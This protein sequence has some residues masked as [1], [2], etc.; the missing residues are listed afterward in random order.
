MNIYIEV[1]C[2]RNQSKKLLNQIGSVELSSLA[3]EIEHEA[4]ADKYT[5]VNNNPA[6]AKV[7]QLPAP[8]QCKI[9]ALSSIYKERILCDALNIEFDKSF[10]ILNDGA[11]AELNSELSKE[12]VR[13]QT[14]EESV[15]GVITGSEIADGRLK[16][17]AIRI[18]CVFAALVITYFLISIIHSIVHKSNESTIKIG[19][20]DNREPLSQ[21]SAQNSQNEL[22][23]VSQPNVNQ[24]IASGLAT[25]SMDLV[26][27]MGKNP[28]EVDATK[29]LYAFTDPDCPYCK[30]IE[31][32]F[33]ALAKEG[34]SI[35][36]FPVS[37]HDS[38][39]EKIRAIAC[40][41][42]GDKLA[43]W[44]RYFSDATIKSD[45][46]CSS[47]ADADI[48]AFNFFNNAGLKYTPTLINDSGKI[49]VGN[50]SIDAIKE[51]L[52]K[53]N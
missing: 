51:F 9:E 25:P 23:P 47:G 43:L 37:V 7:S 35:T 49:L 44:E 53:L 4:D 1:L 14:N 48:R 39:I 30:K 11:Q 19:A 24:K 33:E 26:V 5:F 42:T 41:K 20:Y 28:G 17:K 45:A 27:M 3:A 12:F 18:A 6:I 31:V 38:S 40:A 2:R 13:N 50:Q 21:S 8:I 46:K 15:K 22:T 34:Y 52:K 36:I 10:Y 32:N 16:S 29:R